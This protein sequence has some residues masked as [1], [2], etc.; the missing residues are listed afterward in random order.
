MLRSPAARRSLALPP[1]AAPA[2]RLGH[3]APVRRPA[4]EAQ[5]NALLDSFAENLLQL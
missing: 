3:A 4:S 5:A 1:T 2:A